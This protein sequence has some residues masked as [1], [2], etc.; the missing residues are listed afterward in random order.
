MPGIFD[1][2]GGESLGRNNWIKV[3]EES[4]TS[5]ARETFLSSRGFLKPWREDGAGGAGFKKLQVWPVRLAFTRWTPSHAESTWN[6]LET[7]DNRAT[8][9]DNLLRT[10][11]ESSLCY[12]A[13]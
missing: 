7:R 3:V 13:E 10:I 5:I 1:R 2:A 12:S 6:A 4:E 8:L 11:M 9:T